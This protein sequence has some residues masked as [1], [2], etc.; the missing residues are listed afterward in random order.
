MRRT[1]RTASGAKQTLRSMP[2]RLFVEKEQI[3]I[4]AVQEAEV[5]KM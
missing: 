1:E 5:R 2:E 4:A 3:G